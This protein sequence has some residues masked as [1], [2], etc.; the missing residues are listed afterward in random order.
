MNTTSVQS[1]VGSGEDA[2]RPHRQVDPE[3]LSGGPWDGRAFSYVPPEHLEVDPQLPLH[4]EFELDLDPV[5]Y[6]VLRNRLWNMN[7]DHS[8]TIKRVSGTAVIVYMD[9]FNTS[10]LTEDGDSVVCGPSVQYFTGHGDLAV[11]WTLENRSGNPGIADGDVWLQNDPYIGTTHQPDTLLYAPVFWEG[12]L[13]CWLLS[14]C[15]MGDL[16]GVTPGSFCPDAVDMFE[17]PAP[18]AA[19][20]LVA[21]GELRSDV[22]DMFTRFSR[23]PEMVALQLRSQIAG[24]NAT[25]ARMVEALEE[26]GARVV[27]GAMRRIISDTSKAVGERL[28]RIP[29]G[30]WEETIYIGNAA[31]GDR[32]VHRMVTS[33][34]KEGD[35]L[36]FSNRGTDEQFRAAN[37][38]FS[39]WR[40]S[41]V[42]AGCAFMA[43]DQRFCPA[44][45]VEHMQFE[46]VPGTLNCATYPG[47]VTPLTGVLVCMALAGQVMSKMLATGPADLRRR[48]NATGGVTLPGWWI[49]SGFDR[50]GKYI[51]DLTGDS[52]ASAIGGF[53]FRDGIDTGGAWWWPKPRAGNAEEWEQSLPFLYL[54][55]REQVD[56][57]GAGEWRGGNCL[58]IAVS[59]HKC[60]G[61]HFQ[62]IA[63]DPA[64]NT[65]PGLGGGHPGH[66][67]NQ[68]RAVGNSLSEA[69]AAGV[70]P[71]S[72]GAVEE[73]VGEIERL[74]PKA[75]VDVTPADVILVDYS[76]GGGFGDPLQRV[77]ELV[78]ADVAGGYVS[79]EKARVAYGVV[80]REGAVDLVATEELRESTRR[81]RLEEGQS[82]EPAEVP[83]H[84]VEALEP[85]IANLAVA[86]TKAGRRWACGRCGDDLGRL[87]E[88][89]KRRAARIDNDP[90]RIDPVAYPDPADFCDPEISLRQHACA[91]CGALLSSEFCKAEDDV[92]YDFRLALSSDD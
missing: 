67:G 66:P 13:F 29:D 17:E 56:S 42:S 20:K 30:E 1:P 58:E 83:A 53:S 90:H 73:V 18:V 26:Y 86:E 37:C 63:C 8:D 32:D 27:K 31:T 44:G 77:A 75:G 74:A 78:A 14:N 48:V 7:L 81:A 92:T 4:D 22:A 68:Q 25:K 19:I 41:L 12:R 23:T 43:W 35:Q 64:I 60:E 46:P 65:A 89:Y 70:L 71:G 24:L 87:D 80:L 50:D 9:D 15:H 21:E 54:Y 69:F 51:V 52:I 47:A 84:P 62:F 61:L 34:R 49:A 3:K 57:G 76:S 6:E 88:N 40:S 36:I 5:T 91:S 59:P 55:R 28:A 72:R 38:T 82:P 39:S 10:M 2:R 11:K 33:M 16:G 45:V 79:A 85:V